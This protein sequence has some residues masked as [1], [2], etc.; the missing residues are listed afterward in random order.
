MLAF[1]GGIGEHAAGVRA[2]IVGRVRFLAARRGGR[3]RAG[4]AGDRAV[5]QAAP[6]R[7]E[8]SGTPARAGLDAESDARLL[9]LARPEV[10]LVR[11][12]RRPFNEQAPRAERRGAHRVV[13]DVVDDPLH[14][15]RLE[16]EDDLARRQ[17]RGVPV[18]PD[19][20]RIEWRALVQEPPRLLVRSLA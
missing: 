12:A 20:L 8:A 7:R 2:A 5:G 13:D 1:T 19:V 17:V 4:G 18:Q 11:E 10:A 3:A 16:Q 6:W 15:G 14:L 9:L